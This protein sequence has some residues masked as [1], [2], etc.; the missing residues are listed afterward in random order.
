MNTMSEERARKT[1]TEL[2]WPN[3]EIETSFMKICALRKDSLDRLLKKKS[4]IESRASAT[5]QNEIDALYREWKPK[6]IIL[7]EEIERLLPLAT[8]VQ[9][10]R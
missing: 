3:A 10:V 6:E 9:V 8:P 4:E 5:S 1:H 2:R 7:C